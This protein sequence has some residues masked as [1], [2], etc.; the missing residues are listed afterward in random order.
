MSKN[1]FYITTTLPYVNADPHIGF[2]MEIV[3]AD[4]VARLHQQM[5]EEVIFNFGTDEHG[6]KIYRKALEQ[7]KEPQDYADEYAARFDNLKKALNLSYNYFIRTTDMHH[8]SA[9]FEFWKRCKANGD[10]YK[11]N[12][13]VKYCV[14]CELEKTNS[15]LVDEKCPIHPNLEIEII[16]EE[17]YFFKFS[18]YQQ[19]LLDFYK[20]NPDFVIPE[21]KF[22]E[23]K[24]FVQSGLEDF[25]ISRL[26]SKMPWGIDVPGDLQQ[27]MYVWFDA[28]INY[29]STLGWPEDRQKFTDFWPGLQ[30]AG[31]DNLRQQSAIWQAMLMSAGLPNTKQIFIHGFMTV[32]G[33]KISKSLGTSIDP[34]AMADKYGTDAVR[35]FLLAKVHPYDGSD[36]SY[37]KF[38]EAY[39]S[40]LA[41]GLCQ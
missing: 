33:Q 15:E 5:G 39:N 30:V 13:R 24:S 23:I 28:L 36:F 7:G 19:P 40:D 31:L 16:E 35:Y 29:I 34:I 20:K 6:L 26:K 12:Y 25:S 4:A 3:E 1:K 21:G 10:I 27:V 37:D 18:K 17:N 41:N 14:G 2:A 8:K 11:K 32:N 9:A 38:E 22:N